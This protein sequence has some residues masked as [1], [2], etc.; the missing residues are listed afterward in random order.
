LVSNNEIHR[1]SNRAEVKV[2]NDFSE[3]M[4]STVTT[5]KIHRIGVEE[6]KKILRYRCDKGIN[7]IDTAN[8]YHGGA[9]PVPL[10]HAEYAEKLLGKLISQ[11]LE[12]KSLLWLLRLEVGCAISPTVKA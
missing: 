11:A 9:S 12:E 3:C 10:T 6:F 2:S 4:I 1:L 8:R 7:F 5:R